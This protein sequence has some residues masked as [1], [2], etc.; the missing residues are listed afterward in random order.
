MNDDLWT[1]IADLL[2]KGWSVNLY[3][4]RC[5]TSGKYAVTIKLS[6]SL[7]GRDTQTEHQAEGETPEQALWRALGESG[8]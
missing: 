5:Q 4:K 8:E 1:K 6:H 7:H 3:P 2:E